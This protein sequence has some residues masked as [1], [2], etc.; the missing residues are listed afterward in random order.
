LTVTDTVLIKPA[1]LPSIMR[2]QILIIEDNLLESTYLLSILQDTFEV[3]MHEKC[4]TALEWLN[5]NIPS[6]IIADL[7][8]PDMS[9]YEFIAKAKSL[10][11]IAKIPLI[12]VSGEEKEWIKERC[13]KVGANG[14]FVKPADPVE[15]R[16]TIFSLLSLE[17][18][19][20]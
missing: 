2:P 6:L 7:H 4:L 1:K 3:I 9:G 13:I 11:K 5:E 14:F 16:K 12:V 10:K 18:Y 17:T 19:S 15:L 20:N 8:I